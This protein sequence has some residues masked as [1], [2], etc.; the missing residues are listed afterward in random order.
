[1]WCTTIRS[2]RL[3]TTMIVWLN[4]I[5]L[6][7]HLK[8]EHIFCSYEGTWNHTAK[9][10]DKVQRFL[11]FILFFFLESTALTY[12][13]LIWIIS[14]YTPTGRNIQL[15]MFNIEYNQIMQQTHFARMHALWGNN[16]TDDVLI[17]VYEMKKK[18]HFK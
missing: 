1:M 7:N 8:R 13:C 2:H 14:A 6:S 4:C 12:G 17:C 15:V 9:R 16:Y 18:Y 5:S 10:K 3:T 11:R